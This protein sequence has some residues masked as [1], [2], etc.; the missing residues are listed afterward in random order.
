MRAAWSELQRV[1]AR[2][3]AFKPASIIQ[4][5]TLDWMPVLWRLESALAQL[6]DAAGGVAR[7]AAVLRSLCAPKLS[8]ATLIDNSDRRIEELRRRGHDVVFEGPWSLGRLCAV[9]RD[10]GTGQL[11]AA[12]NPR[13]MQGYAVG[14]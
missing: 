7:S 12:A 1:L 9:G 4:E 3:R 10:P 6:R 8:L 11:L 14:R 5:L 2:L 13:G